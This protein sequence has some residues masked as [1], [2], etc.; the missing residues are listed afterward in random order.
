MT[1]KDAA[2]IWGVITG[3]LAAVS[4]RGLFP[5]NE[6]LWLGGLGYIASIVI[7]VTKTDSKEGID[8]WIGT[9]MIFIIYKCATG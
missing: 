6:H 5:P 1:R 9:Q 4:M 3:I 8:W 7:L 2:Q